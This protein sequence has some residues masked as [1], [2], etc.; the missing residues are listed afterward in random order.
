MGN[1]FEQEGCNVD[2]R[3]RRRLIQLLKKVERISLVVLVWLLGAAVLYGIYTAAL[4]KP[5]FKV[6]RIEVEG[7][8]RALSKE[9]VISKSGINMGDHLLRMPVGDIQDK[10]SKNPWI[11]EVAVHRKFPNK[12]WIYVTEYVPEAIVRTSD[13]YYV[14]RFGKFFKKLDRDDDKNFPVI[15]GLEEFTIKDKDGFQSKIVELL[16]VKKLYEESSMGEIYGLSEVHFNSNWGVSVVTLV[17][18]IE[19]R[20]GFGPFREKINRLQIVYP[21]IRSHG[22]IVAYIDLN[23]EGKVV[24]KYGT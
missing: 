18:P 2:S 4:L 5:Y 1:L 20:L 7:N 13:W 11:K 12:I 16:R 21:A 6:E 10:L 9:D 8:L 24:V 22:G 19:L 14:D 17:D 3:K 23:S 15:T